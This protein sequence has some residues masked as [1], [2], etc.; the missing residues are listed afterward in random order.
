MYVDQSDSSGVKQTVLNDERLTPV[1][2]FLRR[3]NLDELPQ[4]INVIKG[5]M[6]L[7]GPR[8]HV[9]DMLAAGMKYELLVPE[10][11]DRHRA[12]PGLT[13][14][15]QALG[16]RGSTEDADLAAARIKMD[17]RYIEHWSFTLDLLIIIKTIWYE[18]T[19][20]GSGI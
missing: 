14:L 8:P 9:P 1:G 15:A 3:F 17:L 18:I 12:K 10:Y 6:S 16:F 20:H 11:F 4:L 5:E 7:V 13:G 19:H 2:T